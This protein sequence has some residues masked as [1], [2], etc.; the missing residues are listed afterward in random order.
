MSIIQNIDEY[1]NLSDPFVWLAI[2]HI[3]FN[4]MFWNISA[5]L[6]YKQ[7]L[8][9]KIFG[10]TK[11]A[12]Y[13]L[14]VTTFT[15]GLT[16]NL[17]VILAVTRQLSIESYLS[18][19]AINMMKYGGILC[20][21]IGLVFAISSMFRLGITGT[22]LGDYFGMLKDERVTAFPYNVCGNPMYVGS[23]IAFLGLAITRMSPIGLL[24]TC[25][26]H[27][28]YR[29]ALFFEEPFTDKIY[30]QRDQSKQVKAQ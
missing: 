9:S 27:L 26:I 4:P 29:V 1:V 5:R 7:K 6:E 20:I 13:A 18:N 17:T 8:L 25:Y 21:I 19:D 30:S 15:I 11:A 28:V 3:T 24:F 10:S 14:A 2:I 23:T 22:Y 16:R 12:C